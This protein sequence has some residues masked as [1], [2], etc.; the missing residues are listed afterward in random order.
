M[1]T[2]PIAD[3]LTRIRNAARAR[4]ERAE[5]PWSRLKEQIARVMAAEGYV[6]EVAVTGEGRERRLCVT[7]RYDKGRG[8]VISGLRRVS[9]PGL[10]VYAGAAEIPKVQDGLGIS[11]LS[12]SKG[13][14]VDRE[15][16][17]LGIG[18]EVLVSVW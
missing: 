1:M 5:I 11:I 14:L 16:R 2:D 6:A 9:A 13:V 8:S 15:A 7:L 17:R 4:H 3:L 18:G 12:T 10:R